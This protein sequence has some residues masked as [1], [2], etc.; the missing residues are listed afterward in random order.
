ME[1]LRA[2]ACS[3]PPRQQYQLRQNGRLSHHNHT[4]HRLCIHV[5]SANC[6]P[7]FFFYFIS[8]CVCV[9][10]DLLNLHF[11]WNVFRRNGWWFAGRVADNMKTVWVHARRHSV[12]LMVCIQIRTH[13]A[14][15]SLKLFLALSFRWW[16]AS[17][18]HYFRFRASKEA[19]HLH[20]VR[21]KF[22][23]WMVKHLIVAV[24]FT[25]LLN[26]VKMENN[27][28]V[29]LQRVFI[30]KGTNNEPRKKCV[31]EWFVDEWQTKRRWKEWARQREWKRWA[32]FFFKIKNKL[33]LERIN[34]VVRCFNV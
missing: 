29:H 10:S 26:V 34:G 28:C 18:W 6:A 1:S 9:A 4:S 19:I 25:I 11:L 24:E 21:P 22:S 14:I 23:V 16:T 12:Q 27:C 33:H 15:E 31:K 20:Q 3:Q 32:A 17:G 7:V 13:T 8:L 2:C 30:S 5:V